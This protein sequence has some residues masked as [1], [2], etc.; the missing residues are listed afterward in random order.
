[1]NHLL[2]VFSRPFRTAIFPMLILLSM[3]FSNAATAQ[4]PYC[5]EIFQNG[6]QTHGVYQN[7]VHFG[8]NAR[9]TNASS[10]QLRVPTVTSNQWSLLKSCGSRHCEAGGDPA[11]KI[12]YDS[13]PGTG[14]TREYLVPA[15]KKM[16]L[17]EDV[18]AIGKVELKE[19]ATGEFSSRGNF[20]VIDRL[21]LGFKSTLRLPEGNYYVRSFRMEVESRIE[22]IG[23]GTVNLFVQNHLDVPF[24]ARINANTQDPSRLVIYTESSSQFHV[25]SKT[26]AFI[27]TENELILSHAA[28]I[29]GGLVAQYIYLESE[30][31]VIFDS[32]AASHISIKDRCRDEYSS[33]TFPD[34]MVLIEYDPVVVTDSNVAPIYASLDSRSESNI[35][36]ARATV[37]TAAGEFYPE[38]IGGVA[39]F[40]E[41]ELTVGENY[42]T[43]TLEDLYGNE[44][45]KEM[46]IPYYLPPEFHNVLPISGT[47][48]TTKD[49][50][51]TGEIKTDWPFEYLLLLV[52]GDSYPIDLS[53]EGVARFS[54][55]K[56]LEDESQTFLLRLYSPS[57]VEVD[58][59]IQV[60]Y[61]PPI[62][63]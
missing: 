7:A 47:V 49:I 61:V 46:R 16:I 57:P 28:K 14:S 11:F 35:P 30:S 62:T 2:D 42:F 56:T 55:N 31:E 13:L 9:I 4:L 32:A 27:V 50:V 24:K 40:F 53:T 8:Y 29:Y 18:E 45:S 19:Y 15:G 26:Y 44:Y 52:N 25:L 20:Y 10:P 5:S 63:D 36:I 38:I 43:V 39:A 12:W 22:V 6:V 21:F 33:P 51:I 59:E 41:M 37:S 60:K 34:R 1:M 54:I 58:K 48:F 3:V 17:G 23:E